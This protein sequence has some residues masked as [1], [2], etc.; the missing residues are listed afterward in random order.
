L[1]LK[2]SQSVWN[3]GMEGVSKRERKKKSKHI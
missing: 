1:K 2:C 3:H